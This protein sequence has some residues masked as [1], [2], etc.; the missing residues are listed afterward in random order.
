[1]CLNDIGAVN[2]AIWLKA[3]YVPH[4]AN[5]K[6]YYGGIMDSVSKREIEKIKLPSNSKVVTAKSLWHYVGTLSKVGDTFTKDQLKNNSPSVGSDDTIKRNLAY[7]KYLGII[8]E[9]REVGKKGDKSENT[10]WFNFKKSENVMALKNASRADKD[11]IARGHFKNVLKD[12]PLYAVIVKGLFSGENRK[13]V[14]D[15]ENFLVKENT[16]KKAPYYRGATTFLVNLLGDFGLVRKEGDQ[17]VLEDNITEDALI[18]EKEEKISTESQ[19]SAEQLVPTLN[20]SITV[21]VRG[22]SLNT[23]MVI[24]NEDDITLLNAVITWIKKE[25]GVTEHASS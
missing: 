1:M 9:S 3:H 7:L 17:I 4:K 23:S 15:L 6:A 14:I 2:G 24:K 18:R 11:E 20:G 10:Q 19:A 13:T 16:G 8:E 21:I 12:H 25:V 5:I 22:D